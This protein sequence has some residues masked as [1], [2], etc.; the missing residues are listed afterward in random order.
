MPNGPMAIYVHRKP[1]AEAKFTISKSGANITDTF[2][3]TAY[4]LD[5]QSIANKGIRAREWYFKEVG[6]T[7]WTFGGSG[8]GFTLNG[9]VTKDYLVKHRVQDI[10][11]EGGVG[12]WSED[13]VILVTTQPLPPVASFEISPI[14][15]PINTVM[16]LYDYSYDTNGD[17]I[18]EY[19]WTLK[20][21][22]VTRLTRTLTNA[23]GVTAAQVNTVRD[24]LKST[25][26]SLGHSAYGKWILELQVRD[27]SSAT[28]GD[29]LATSD[30]IT[31]IF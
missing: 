20:K 2:N 18:V 10:D 28:W 19:R 30:V 29:T 15:Y 24:A 21:D 13:N 9:L 22:G 4:D 25:I 17:R 3:P 5:H 23:S 27:S 6:A 12:V 1:L 11:G 26:D 14:T 16:N 31:R 8:I 7:N